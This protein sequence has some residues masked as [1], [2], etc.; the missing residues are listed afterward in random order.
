MLRSHSNCCAVHIYVAKFAGNLVAKKKAGGDWRVVKA[1]T[2]DE[3]VKV[4]LQNG[5]VCEGEVPKAVEFYFTFSHGKN[6]W[7]WN[8][9]GGE[10]KDF[11]RQF[12]SVADYDFELNKSKLKWVCM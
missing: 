5:V 4:D 2:V 7:T 8:Q 11:K 6:A 9:R 12:C 1:K 10:F 3:I